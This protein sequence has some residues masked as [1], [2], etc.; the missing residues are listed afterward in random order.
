VTQTEFLQKWIIAIPGEDRAEFESD[1][2][3]VMPSALVEHIGHIP[4]RRGT[5]LLTRYNVTLKCARPLVSWYGALA[6]LRKDGTPWAWPPKDQ[7]NPYKQCEWS[8]ELENAVLWE[9]RKV[10]ELGGVGGRK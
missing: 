10:G 8:R 6:G 3:S 2:E 5:G 7:S 1:L 9:L 4:S